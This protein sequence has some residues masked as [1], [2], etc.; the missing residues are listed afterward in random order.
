MG[1]FSW[2]VWTKANRQPS[3]NA[4]P[5][6]NRKN[7]KQQPLRMHFYSK[8]IQKE[9][10][11]TWFSKRCSAVVDGS[12]CALASAEQP[13]CLSLQW[14]E[15]SGSTWPNSICSLIRNKNTFGTSTRTQR[16][17]ST[18]S[19]CRLLFLFAFTISCIGFG[20]I[21][22][23]GHF[24]R[25]GFLYFIQGFFLSWPSCCSTTVHQSFASE[26]RPKIKD[27]SEE[28]CI[29]TLLGIIPLFFPCCRKPLLLLAYLADAPNL[30]CSYEH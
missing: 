17:P 14:C 8:L 22:Q 19:L 10:L 15:A 28:W 24:P 30:L 29:W 12:R 23:L 6:Q 25:P 27:S 1:C 11:K 26:K 3:P 2:P 7:L 13:A 4:F 18:P 16:G 9:T 21:D 5:L 20:L